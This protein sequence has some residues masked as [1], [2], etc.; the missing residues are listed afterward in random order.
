MTVYSQSVSPSPRH[1]E[2]KPNWSPPIL[3]QLLLAGLFWGMAAFGFLAS[4]QNAI[5]EGKK[6]D[7]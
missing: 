6:S 4:I 3:L 5:R 2:I 1:Y 7:K